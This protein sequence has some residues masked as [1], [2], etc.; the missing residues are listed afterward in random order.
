MTVAILSTKVISW[1]YI[2]RERE[3]DNSTLNITMFL[4]EN[5]KTQ[6]YKIKYKLYHRVGARYSNVTNYKQNT[7][8]YVKNKYFWVH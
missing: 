7:L 4:M 2:L 8:L 3:R 6:F 5:I 1:Y